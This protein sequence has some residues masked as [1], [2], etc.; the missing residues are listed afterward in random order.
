[1]LL[2]AFLRPPGLH[3][4]AKPS[5]NFSSLGQCDSCTRWVTSTL[6]TFVCAAQVGC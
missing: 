3:D 1:L 4:A 2:G 5:L 6:C